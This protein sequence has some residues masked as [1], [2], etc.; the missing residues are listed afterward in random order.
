MQ[1][2]RFS[3]NKNEGF[4]LCNRFSLLLGIL[5]IL[6]SWL[7]IEITRRKLCFRRIVNLIKKI[8]NMTC[9]IFGIL[10]VTPDSFSDGGE[11]FEP[12]AAISRVRE[13]I[14]EGA[15]FI[16]MGGESTRPMATPVSPEEEW[17]RAER[18]VLE[19]LSD[20]DVRSKISLDTR[21]WET[22][23]KFFRSGG[24]VLND[25]SGVGDE[26]MQELVARF[27]KKV[28][29]GHFPGKTLAEVHEQ[30]IDSV[31]QVCDELLARHKELIC[32]GIA[33]E[34]IILDPNIGFGK[35]ME[36]NLELL[37]IATLLPGHEVMIGHSRKRFLGEHRYEIEPNLAAA[38]IAINS[39][40]RYLRVH[41]VWEHAHLLKT[42]I[43]KN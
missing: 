16:D 38:Q 23:E 34:A 21:H 15:S 13:M 37:K 30:K 14:N 7:K 31:N 3:K 20:L 12:E 1:C 24:E 33:P 18:V 25:V 22:A 9:D 32:A 41:D 39:G 27:A 29:V 19:F 11:F 8:K 4:V 42:L 5:S 17:N 40:A 43:D 6:S 28:I 2:I 10:N 35:T 36:C 26:R